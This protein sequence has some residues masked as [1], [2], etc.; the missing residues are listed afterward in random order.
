MKFDKMPSADAREKDP[1]AVLD[2]I[3][4]LEFAGADVRRPKRNRYQL[5]LSPDLNYYPTIG[6]IVR[7]GEDALEACGLDAVIELLRREGLISQ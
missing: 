2:A 7:D 4:R 5:K 3:R 1:K 6:R